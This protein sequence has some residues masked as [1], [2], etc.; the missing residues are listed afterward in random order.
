MLVLDIFIDGNTHYNPHFYFGKSN[1]TNR[2]AKV[3]RD[4]SDELVIKFNDVELAK[5]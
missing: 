4:F 2:I 5:K 3:E 1:Y